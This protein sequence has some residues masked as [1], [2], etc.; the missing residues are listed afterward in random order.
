VNAVVGIDATDLFCPGFTTPIISLIKK[1]VKKSGNA[2]VKIFEHRAL[3]R[4]QHICLSYNWQVTGYMEK[5]G[6]FYI[7]ITV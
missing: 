2:V 3:L 1:L 6:V 7:A 4:L 5:D